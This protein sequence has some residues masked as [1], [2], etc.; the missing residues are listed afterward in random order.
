MY[1]KSLAVAQSLIT[2]G[3]DVNA[4][5]NEGNTALIT[6]VFLK[7]RQSLPILKGFN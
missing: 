6:Q 2:K 4:K 7:D 1:V 3:A 5:N